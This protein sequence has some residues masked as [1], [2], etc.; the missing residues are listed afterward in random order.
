MIMIPN[1]RLKNYDEAIQSNKTL[2]HRLRD[3]NDVLEL[4]NATRTLGD[5]YFERG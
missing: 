5:I 1:Y 3:M 2:I 4:R